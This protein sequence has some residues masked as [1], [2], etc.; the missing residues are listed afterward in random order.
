MSVLQ[1]NYGTTTKKVVYQEVLQ[2][3]VSQIQNVGHHP[4]SK[5]NR[6][7]YKAREQTG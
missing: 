6:E 5:T 1:A 3:N 7:G 2:E 4:T